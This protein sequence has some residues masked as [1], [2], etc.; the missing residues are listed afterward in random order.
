MD[1]D[2]PI[3]RFRD[4]SRRWLRTLHSWLGGRPQCGI[5]RFL[6][7]FSPAILLAVLIAQNAVNARVWDG[8]ENAVLLKHAREG[9]LTLE[10]LF[11]AHIDHRMF[12]P[13]LIALATA[14]LTGGD[15][16]A[17]MWVT[18]FVMLGG[19][20][21][22][23]Y[24]VRKTLGAT[25][26]VWGTAFSINLVIF[27]PLQYQNWL[28][29]VQVAMMLPLA[30]LCGLVALL[31]A[32][33]PPLWLKLVGGIVLAEI[34]TF[35]FGH[36]LILWPVAISLGLMLKGLA[37]P[38]R[39]ALFVG[40]WLVAA[41]LTIY[42]YF[43]VN[44]INTS[45]P[46]HAY[47]Q[48]PG[49]RPPGITKMKSSLADQDGRE[50]FIKR[51]KY[52][53]WSLLGN[54]QTRLFGADPAASAKN[55]GRGCFYVFLAG[56]LWMLSRWKSTR[57]WNAL[58]PWAALGG[59][60]VVAASLASVGRGNQA[61]PRAI[62]SR[63]ISMTTFL[64]IAIIVIA[65]YLLWRGRRGAWGATGRRLCSRAALIL[66]VGFGALQTQQWVYGAHKM[67]AWKLA[68]LEERFSLLYLKHFEPRYTD[69][70]DGDWETGFIRG[71]AHYLND[72]GLLD[73]PMFESPDFGTFARTEKPLNPTRGG[74]LMAA[75]NDPETGHLY[76]RGYA[77]LPGGRTAD[78]ILVTWRPAGGGAESGDW[79]LLDVIEMYPAPTM[80]ASFAD[81]QFGENQRNFSQIK[82]YARFEKLIPTRPGGTDKLPRDS[83]I[84]LLLWAADTE[85]MVVHPFKTLA[86]DR[87]P[88]AILASGKNP[89]GYTKEFVPGRDDGPLLIGQGP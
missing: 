19:G 85:K 30:C 37:G 42:T 13:R 78:G 35:S 1:S 44:F 33:R 32:R 23:F 61:L 26:W 47:G 64:V 9:T 20:L 3:G 77:A 69:R 34:G 62:M 36:G 67:N 22:L 18:F 38:G 56:C 51:A 10:Y 66:G 70:I 58:L 82:H 21:C 39:R 17:D 31:C 88:A 5:L 65:A 83:K 7:A 79:K 2:N 73:P 60:S 89:S 28:W 27:T 57:D 86:D 68:R 49:E 25:N 63:Y 74:K 43:N 55:V 48:K 53:F 41:T 40:A 14:A 76:L 11:S 8:W 52:Y 6:L 59:F 29:A 46:I 84:E 72:Q 4:R 75:A 81:G 45:Q 80:R 87:N 16:R 50:R 24:L 54:S 12:F 71:L 15:L